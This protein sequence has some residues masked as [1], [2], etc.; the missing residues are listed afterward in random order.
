MT[1]RQRDYMKAIRSIA[2]RN[3]YPPSLAEISAE[4]GTSK[5]VTRDMV[6][7]LERNGYV[8]R[9][10]ATA[11]SIRITDAGRVALEGVAK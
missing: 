5:G 8:D 6:L 3:G 10:Y 11:R 1:K 2:T 9:D 4:A 7:L